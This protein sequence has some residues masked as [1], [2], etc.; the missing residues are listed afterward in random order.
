[1]FCI[2]VIPFFARHK[3]EMAP[4]NDCGARFLVAGHAYEHLRRDLIH[5]ARSSTHAFWHVLLVLLV[6]SKL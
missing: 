4:Y 1:M 2:L 6:S 5:V 3:Q